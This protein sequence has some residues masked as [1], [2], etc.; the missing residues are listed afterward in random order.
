MTLSVTGRPATAVC[1]T[2]WMIIDGDMEIMFVTSFEKG[3]SLP[4]AL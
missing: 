4:L 2:G 3:L 1:V